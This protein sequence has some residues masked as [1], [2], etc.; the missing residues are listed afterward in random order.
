MKAGKSTLMLSYGNRR[1]LRQVSPIGIQ[2]FVKILR[3]NYIIDSGAIKSTCY[4]SVDNTISPAQI[5]P[6]GV[7][8]SAQIKTTAPAGI[9]SAL[10]A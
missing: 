7:K 8:L 3:D 1:R 10:Y 2:I 4:T 6:E 5:F 9:L